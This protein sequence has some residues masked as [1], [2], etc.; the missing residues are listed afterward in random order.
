[1]L[2]LKE[3]ETIVFALYAT[4]RY[5]DNLDIARYLIQRECCLFSVGKYKYVL[6]VDTRFTCR[7]HV[8]AFLE[9]TLGCLFIGLVKALYFCGCTPYTRISVSPKPD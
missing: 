5:H 8:S 4:S 9:L 3:V 6:S 1:M 2:I 7:I